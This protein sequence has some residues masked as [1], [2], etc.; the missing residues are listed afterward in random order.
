MFGRTK[1]N[2]QSVFTSAK[3]FCERDRERKKTT[4]TTHRTS[5]F[6]CAYLLPQSVI[7]SEVNAFQLATTTQ[8]H[9]DLEKA[10]Q[11]AAKVSNF[12]L[13]PDRRSMVVLF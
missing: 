4:T 5:I 11:P 7:R 8:R 3:R 1:A 13:L 2:Q 10:S 12:N 9:T 6:Q